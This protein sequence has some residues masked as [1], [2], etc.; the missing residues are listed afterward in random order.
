MNILVVYAHQEPTSL[1]A[2]LKNIGL[3]I[4]SSQGHTVIESDLYGSGFHPV[5]GKYDFNT[6]TGAHYN[7][8]LEQQASAKNDWAFAPDI[9]SEMQKVKEAEMIIFYTPVWWHSVPAILKGWFDRVLAMGFACDSGKIYD[10]GLLRGKRVL[11]CAVAGNPEDIYQ[12]L[13]KHRATL[14][15]MLHPIH[16]GIFSFCGMDVMEPFIVYSSMNHT[17][18]EY[19]GILDSH[20][21]LV[22]TAVSNPRYLSKY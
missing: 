22:E 5:A 18:E 20:K 9:V 1:T 3:S 16:Q 15:Q 10:E 12:P 14:K 11:L 7:Y 13:N 17:P 4:L 8:M 21:A 6:L 19:A 2:S